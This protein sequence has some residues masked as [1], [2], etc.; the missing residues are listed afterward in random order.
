MVEI[1]GNWDARFKPLVEAFRKNFA[2]KQDFGAAICVYLKGQKLVDVWAG[3]SDTKTKAPWKENTLT[4]IFSVTKALTALSFLILAYRKKFDYDKPVSFYWPD[5]ALGGKK[6]ITCRLL[7]EHRAGL[8]AVETPLTLRDFADNQSR[9]H[10]ALIMQKPLFVPGSMQAYGAQVWGAY[11]GELFRHVAG[12]SVGQFF[13]REVAQKLRV[14][15]FIGLPP[16]YENDLA[17]LYPV[18][19]FDRLSALIPD[20]IKGETTEG[21]VGRAFISG[22]RSIEQAYMNPSMGPKSVEIFNES[23][24]HRL[25]LPWVNGV[26]HARSLATVMNV[27]ALG[28]KSGKL[29]F[30]NGALMAELMRENPLRYDLV[31]QKPLGWNLGFLKEE[32]WLYSPNVEAFG[33]S[34]MGGPL[35]LADPKAKLAFGY[36]CNKMDY[37][38][39]PDKTLALCRALYESIA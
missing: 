14:D 2:E 24:V 34:G 31:L 21:R 23:W 6:D 7:L 39:R 9:V 30:A 16:E 25:E 20:I 26:A 22:N 3:V 27:L 19:V 37:K 32:R 5:F 8:Y 11:A 17:T 33:H 36:V 1:Q 10:N 29:Q 18:S 13:A 15:C 28:G 12:E 35:A 38:V 4:T